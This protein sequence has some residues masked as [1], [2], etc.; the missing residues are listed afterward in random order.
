MYQST[1]RIYVVTNPYEEGSHD[2]YYLKHIRTSFS[3]HE[4]GQI[5]FQLVER[6]ES[7]HK[8]GITY[9]FLSPKHVRVIHGFQGKESIKL[10]IADIAMM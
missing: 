3:D 7:L 4:I 1:N 10:N 8:N 6:I 5:A 9:K 2:L